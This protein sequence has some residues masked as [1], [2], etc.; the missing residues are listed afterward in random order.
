[1]KIIGW[2]R[3][4]DKAAC[5][6]VVVEASAVEI[7]HG[8]GYTFQGAR[9]ACK[10]GCVIAEGFA[11]ST[12][13]NG[14]HRVIHGMVTTGGCPLEST[15]NDI[16]G[17][18]NEGGDAIAATFYQTPEGDWLPKFGPEHFTEES[19]DEQVEALDAKTGEPIADLAYYIQA[20]DGSTYS[21][22]TDENGL[23]ER[24]TTFHI[25]ELTVWFGEDAEQKRQGA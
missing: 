24:V 19:P 7:S 14:P 17:V 15:L 12:L 18:G 13:S 10:N 6:G 1:M 11:R 2:I 25:E 16:D 21:G 4:G 22:H 3:Y 8:R 5:G 9:M 23:C 20:P